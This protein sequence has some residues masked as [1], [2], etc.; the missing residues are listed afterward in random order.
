MFCMQEL[1]RIMKQQS[2]P[3]GAPCHM[4]N[5]P[6][7]S[8]QTLQAPTSP[9]LFCICTYIHPFWNLKKTF[10]SPPKLDHTPPQNQPNLSPL[11]P[12]LFHLK[13]CPPKNDQMHLHSAHFLGKQQKQGQ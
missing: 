3:N 13:Y 6:E 12:K 9:H 10:S 8:I 2:Y 4:S 11:T 1:A 5:I 7:T